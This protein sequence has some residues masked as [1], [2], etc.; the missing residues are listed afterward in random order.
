MDKSQI[1][2]WKVITVYIVKPLSGRPLKNTLDKS[3]IFERLLPGRGIIDGSVKHN[4]WF[5]HYMK[6][7]R[8]TFSYLCTN[9]IQ[10]SMSLIF[11]R[12]KIWLKNSL[13]SAFCFGDLDALLN[14]KQNHYTVVAFIR[15][16]KESQ[17]CCIRIKI[18][19]QSVHFWLKK[20]QRLQHLLYENFQRFLH[21]FEDHLHLHFCFK[22]H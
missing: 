16:S 21:L 17:G 12:I 10:R 9:T 3:E 22:N 11:V 15:F 14:F 4:Q 6:R 20:F 7:I 18:T 1:L 2:H 19:S 8:S 13:L 5:S